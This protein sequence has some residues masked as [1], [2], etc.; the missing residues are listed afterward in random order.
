[1][2]AKPKPQADPYAPT[3]WAKDTED[4]EC[5]SGQRCLVRRIDPLKLLGSGAIH[6]TDM[7][8]SLIDQR[9]VS[10]KSKGGKNSAKSQEMTTDMALKQALADPAKMQELSDMMDEVVLA[11]VVKPV[12]N[13]EPTDGAERQ[14]GLVYIGMVEPDDK[15]F[16]M[17]FAFAGHR[18]A[19]KFRG[20]L[21]ESIGRLANV[22]SVGDSAQ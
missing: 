2:P 14:P 22:E 6:K 1:M 5:P 18:D 19:A 7:I 11:T 17:Q 10:R 9:H 20:E 8:T 12:L 15:A 16:I 13:P 21:N 4:L 3:A